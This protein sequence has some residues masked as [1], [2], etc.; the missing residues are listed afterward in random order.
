MPGF[1]TRQLND[2]FHIT[3]RGIRRYR[4]TWSAYPMIP[5]GVS[6]NVALHQRRTLGN[7][8]VISLQPPAR[9]SIACRAAGGLIPNLCLRIRSRRPA[10][11]QA[12]GPLRTHCP[13]LR[14][15]VSSRRTTA[16][17]DRPGHHA[18]Q[19]RAAQLRRPYSSHHPRNDFDR[20]TA[21]GREP[22][23]CPQDASSLLRMRPASIAI[24]RLAPGEQ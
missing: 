17:N 22:A 14:R 4:I 18:G 21:D 12:A 2:H 10:E 13:G 7:Q 11:H 1:S 8:N 24:I 6:S 3:T 16:S 9:R 19:D 20:L 5:R 23:S 15:V